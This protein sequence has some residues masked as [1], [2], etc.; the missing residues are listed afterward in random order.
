M[1]HFFFFF[2]L[3]SLIYTNTLTSNKINQFFDNYITI[4]YSICFDNVV[5]ARTK[6]SSL[7]VTTT[8]IRLL[9][10]AAHFVCIRVCNVY[11]GHACV[12][13]HNITNP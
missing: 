2:W 7:T 3:F 4:T 11:T 10:Y 1:I 5:V 12:S 6:V 8:E 9:P 13:Q